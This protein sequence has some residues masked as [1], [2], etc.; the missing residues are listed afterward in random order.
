LE[1]DVMLRK[2][3]LGWLGAALLALMTFGAVAAPEKSDKPQKK[4]ETGP[5]N[6]KELQKSVKFELGELKPDEVPNKVEGDKQ[7]RIGTITYPGEPYM[8]KPTRVFGYYARPEKPEEKKIPAMVLVHG[9]GGTAFP[10]W[11]KLWAARGYAA[12]AMDLAGCGDNRVK[13][14]D[15]GPGQDDDTKFRRLKHGVENM[16]SYHAVAAVI[17]AVSVLREMPEVDKN[18]IGITGISWGGYLTSIV[19]SLDSR[20][21]CAVP[22]YGCGYLQ[23]NSAWVP[24]L[25]SLPEAERR[26][27]VELF[28]PSSYLSRCKIPVLWM[29]GTNDFAY[30]LDSYQKSYR[31]MPGLKTL[32]ITVKMPHSHEAGWERPEIGVFVDGIFKAKQLELGLPMASPPLIQ[33]KKVRAAYTGGSAVTKAQLHWTSDLDKPWQQRE[34]KTINANVLGLSAVEAEIPASDVAPRPLVLFMTLTDTHGNVISTEHT[35]YR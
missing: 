1:D 9:G 20:L 8:G 6:L 13:L 23:D 35:E 28:D 16:W 3:S 24:I 30:P 31:S 25:K 19:M 32:C 5:W 29:N 2:I 26:Q 12:I 21:K 18:R 4:S 7:I 11:A 15:G 17:R 14:P 10:Q 34:W 33:V 22:V 27:W